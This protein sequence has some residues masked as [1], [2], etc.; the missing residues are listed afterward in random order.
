MCGYRG[1]RHHKGKLGCFSRNNLNNFFGIGVVNPQIEGVQLNEVENTNNT[2]QKSPRKLKV[3]RVY[4]IL[5]KGCE[6]CLRFCKKGA[7]SMVEGKAFV[8]ETKCVGCGVCVK[9][10]KNDAISLVDRL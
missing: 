5:C 4:P 10:C 1:R 9:G 8:D 6:I 7:I 2:V 3:A